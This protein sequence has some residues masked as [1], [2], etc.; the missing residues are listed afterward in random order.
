M[1]GFQRINLVVSAALPSCL[2]ALSAMAATGCS[3]TGSSANNNAPGAGG[4]SSVPSVPGGGAPSTSAGGSAPSPN[5]GASGSATQASGDPPPDQCGGAVPASFTTTCSACHTPAGTANSRYPDLYQ[6]KGTLADFTM[7]VRTGSAKGMA[8]YSSDLISD[9]DVSAI[10]AYFTGGTT[11]PSIDTVG[12]GGVAPLFSTADAKNPPVV[13]K[14]DDGAI[15]TR[16][17]GRVRGRHE[18]EGSFGPFLAD[19]FENRTYGFIVEDFTPTGAKRIRVTYL[20]IAK[21]DHNGNRITNWRAW[22]EPGNNATFM[23]NKYMNDMTMTDAPMTPTGPFAAV[24]QYDEQVVPNSRTMA[25]GQNFE[26]EF[27]V[28]IDPASLTTAGSRDSYYTDTFRY[29]IGI[30]GM[31]PNNMD[32]DAAP[33]PV[34]DARLGGDTTIAWLF[35]EP[36]MN[37]GEMALNTQ[38]ENVQ[39]FV[40]G[41]RLFHTDFVTGVHSEEGNPVFTAQMGKAGPMYNTTSCENCHINNGPGTTLTGLMDEKSS[42][43]FKLYNAGDLGNQLQL[44]EGSANIAAPETKSVTLGDGTAVMLSKPKFTLTPKAGDA[45]HFSARLA[46]KLVGLG[47]LEAIDERTLLERAD[48][49]DC[50]KDGISGRPSYVKDPQTG[51]LRIGRMGWKAEKVSVQHQVAEAASVDIG[52]SSSIFPEAAA[53][54]KND[55]SDEEL[56][57]LTTYMRLI[58]VPAQRDNQKPDV[59]Q[60][61]QLFK[62]VGCAN[63]HVTDVVT[64]ANHPFAELRNQSI[65]PFTDLLLHDMGPDLAD[66]SGVPASDAADAPPSASEWRT[67]PLW[68]I[69][70][71]KTVN[72]HT[73]LLHDGRA[74][75]PLEAVLWHGGEATK[76]KERFMALP[77]ADRNALL[78]YVNSL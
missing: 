55:L 13:I 33:G 23:E 53:G 40:E 47:L 70:L 71:Y 29:Q 61:E 57:K 10:Y 14:R 35:A 48:R 20:P 56:N 69:G 17:A 44:Q 27:G 68:G 42:M 15:V 5:A 32:Y 39:N 12:L 26:F 51:V 52:L 30:G 45:S 50:D 64:G 60:G 72:G 46:R 59:T 66:D 24:Q 18:K 75:S 25:V 7:H 1:F 6:F 77:T 3:S 16:G 38:Q 76:V 22:K 36:N 19:Y 21:P 54:A 63:C 58:G 67:P 2:V 4:Q 8:A 49:L 78:A 28:F 74:A 73:G 11:R 41:R 65:K 34:P 37:F 62:T 31:T 43:V 9:A